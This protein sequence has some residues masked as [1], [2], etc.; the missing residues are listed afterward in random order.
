MNKELWTFNGVELS[1][2]GK[3][4]VEEVLEGIGVPKY[5]G[6]NLQVPFQHGNR[7]IKKR[8]DHRKIILSMW[9]KGQNRLD[10][11]QKIDEFLRGVAK[12]GLHTLRRT[13]RDGEI[14]ESFGE[15][16][17]ELNF[18]RKAPGYAKFALEIELADPFFY[19][20]NLS[21]FSEFLDSKSHTWTHD[22]LG[23]APLTSM[24]IFFIG[25]MSNPMLMNSN[26]GV[27]VQYLGNINSGESVVLNSKDF[28]CI[29][30]GANVI[31]TV[32]HGGDAYWMI[33]E[34]GNNN[35]KL[36]TETLGGKVETEYYP[37]FF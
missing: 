30:D 21:G 15:L 3:W 17:S 4:D 36:T 35:L 6:S 18:V 28:S 34:G 31:S 20:T 24:L 11:D 23:T 19:G 37:T 9:I 22:Y 32:K 27:W 29:K 2:Y 13:M 1:S 14:R 33:F 16:S 5:R 7:W 10:L 8:Y 25:P 12:P 26:N